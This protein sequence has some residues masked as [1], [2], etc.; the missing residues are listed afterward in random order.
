MNIYWKLIPVLVVIS[1]M[2]SSRVL[3]GQA[4][5]TPT[6]QITVTGTVHDNTI[7]GHSY[8]L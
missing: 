3:P 8:P 5:L 1:L 4:S 7:G 2:L 6:A